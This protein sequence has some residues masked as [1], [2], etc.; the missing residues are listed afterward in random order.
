MYGF[1]RTL[2]EISLHALDWQ[3]DCNTM[4]TDKQHIGIAKVKPNWDFWG[5]IDINGNYLL[6]P[7]CRSIYDWKEGIARLEKVSTN[8]DLGGNWTNHY[9][10][11]YGFINATGKMITDFS[12]GDAN[13]F[14][15]GL[16]AVN[17]NKKWGFIDK[18]GKVTIPFQFDKV[19][20][21]QKE[22]C[23]VSLN[24]KWGLIDRTGKWKLENTFESLSDFAFGLGVA[25]TKNGFALNEKHNF[26][27]DSNGN[28]VVDLPK[29]WTWFK[30]VSEKLILIGTTSGNPGERFYGFMDVQGRIKSKPQFYTTS[31]SLF[32]TGQFANGKL[33]VETK[34]GRKGVVNEEGEF[35]DL[36]SSTIENSK[37]TELQ[38]RPFDEILEFA[39]GLAVARKGRLWG[40]IDENNK[41]VI[42]FKL[43]KRFLRAVGDKGFFFS[44]HSP[45]FS[46]GLI[47]ICEERDNIYSGYIDKEGEIAIELKYRIAEPFFSS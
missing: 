44:E 39:E 21:F 12:F 1:G 22:G 11:D 32:D 5:L 35:E 42:D 6:E 9:N 13:D 33:F 26:I 31:D 23:V 34:D 46:C 2:R 4:T 15:D 40:V 24:N 20:S 3:E 25:S 37:N 16:A 43:Q 7:I 36:N 17:K 19:H 28:K 30:P 41:V 14:S 29:E 47:G 45:K 18:D 27:I 38:H 8:I 10:G